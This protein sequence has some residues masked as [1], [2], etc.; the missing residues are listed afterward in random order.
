MIGRLASTSTGRTT[1]S[2]PR[3]LI[4][5]DLVLFGATIALLGIGGL[6]ATTRAQSAPAA[7]PRPN[8]APAPKASIKA[9]TP[10]DEAPEPIPGGLSLPGAGARPADANPNRRDEGVVPASAAEPPA[11]GEG[12]GGPALPGAK[13][14]PGGGD[15]AG[16]ASTPGGDLAD[17]YALRPDRLQVGKQQVRLSVEVRASAVINLGKETPVRIV[18]TNEG[19]AD[20]ADVRV[21]YRLPDGLQFVSSEAPPQ[22]VPGDPQTYIWNKST[23]A[24]QGEWSIGLKVVAKETKSC[25]HVA[26]VTAKVGSKANTLVQEP[27][28]KVEAAVSPSRILKGGQVKFDIIV[29]NPGTG[30]AKNVNVRATLSDGLKLGDDDVVEQTIDVIKP[31]ERVTLDALMV[32]TV[33]SGKQKCV[34]DVR[35]ADV[36]AVPED[37]R[38]EQAVEVTKPELDAELTGPDFRYTQQAAEYKVAVTNKGTAAAKSVVLAVTL[39]QQGG[40]LARGPLPAGSI[41]TKDRKLFWKIGQLDPGQSFESKF[42]YDT[43][44]VGFYKCAAEATAG[45]LRVSKQVVTEVSGM[46]DLDLKVKQTE[47]V[48]DVGKTTFYDFVIKNVGTKEATKIQVRGT[49]V[50]L[51]VVKSYSDLSKPAEASPDMTQFAFPEL[52]RLAAGA[53]TTLSLEVEALKGGKA[54]AAVEVAHDEMG[55]DANARIKGAITT[56]VTDFNQARPRSSAPAP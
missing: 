55:D 27:K 25:D 54:S 37:H 38:I 32:D 40:R 9:V 13:V 46:A 35:S 51:K 33:A 20:A 47:R 45:E 15:P 12:G 16:P 49:L 22:T 23:M 31:G 17:P 30:P 11:E 19:S 29:S 41:L 50:N 21:T 1:P 28:L 18:V 7:R 26:S 36:N 2:R 3:P 42:V 24:A 56:T 4:R 5:R 14:K 34:I 8:A 43:S 10:A 6:P 53:E 52:P 39:P 48:I 44:T